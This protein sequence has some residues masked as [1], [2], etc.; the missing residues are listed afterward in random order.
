MALMMR[1]RRRGRWRRIREAGRGCNMHGGGRV[2]EGGAQEEAEGEDDEE[3][4]EVED[5]LYWGKKYVRQKHMQ[6]ETTAGDGPC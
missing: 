4:D 6:A 2:E 3:V 1:I 5:E